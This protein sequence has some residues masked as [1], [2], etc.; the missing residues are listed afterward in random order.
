MSSGIAPTL[1]IDPQTQP[2]RPCPVCG[3]ETYAPGYYCIR[4][5]R[6]EP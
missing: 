2:S 6:D 1:Y 5:R 3:A 4:C